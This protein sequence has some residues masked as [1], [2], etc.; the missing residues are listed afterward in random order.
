MAIFDEINFM[1]NCSVFKDEKEPKNL[2]LKEVFASQ[3][4]PKRLINDDIN[5]NII[6][7]KSF[8]R[9]RFHERELVT[10]K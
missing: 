4:S 6:A 3:R 5:K 2:Y 1:E 10:T 8:F 7:P 9:H